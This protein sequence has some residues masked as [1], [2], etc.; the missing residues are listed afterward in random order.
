MSSLSNITQTV[1]PEGGYFSEI[2]GK[3]KEL[4]EGLDI[5]LPEPETN[6]EYEEDSAV[7]SEE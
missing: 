7:E 4:Y 1:F 3:K 2:V 6:I 5:P